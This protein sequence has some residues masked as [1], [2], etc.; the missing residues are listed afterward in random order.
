MSDKAVTKYQALQSFLG[1][2]SLKGALMQ[3]LPP[4]ATPDRL[5]RSALNAILK[6]PLLLECSKESWARSMLEVAML[7]LE[8]NVLGSA[9]MIP[10]KNT[11]KGCYE[12]QVIPG[13]RGLITLACKS[14][15]VSSISAR[16]VHA[17]E[18]FELEYGN[19]TRLSHR[20]CME[21]EPG[22]VLGAYMLAKLSDGDIH[23][24]FMT[25]GQIDLVR[26]RSK[27][28]GNGPWATDYEEMCRKTVTR[29]GIKYLPID[30]SE[31]SQLAN[32]LESEDRFEAGDTPLPI[33]VE[34][35]P[36]D[37]LDMGTDPS[38]PVMNEPK[39]RTDETIGKLKETPLEADSDAK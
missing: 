22:P 16:V 39:S 3:A 32:A 36:G 1:G 33:D 27:A 2:S 30:P 35:D 8:I 12:A 38:E 26:G 5:V 19:E 20:P 15:S 25:K 29:R 37:V 17:G 24:E 31:A 6:D 9:Y 7:G 21:G 10:F 18:F 4:G 23:V 14:K 13:Y 28:G 34:I 11:S